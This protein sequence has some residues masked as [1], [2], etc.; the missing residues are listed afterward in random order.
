[1]KSAKGKMPEKYWQRT[2]CIESDTVKIIDK[3]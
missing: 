2:A 3:W 1:M